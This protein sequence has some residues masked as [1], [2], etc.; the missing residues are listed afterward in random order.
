MKQA[1][2]IIFT[3]LQNRIINLE[4]E[5]GTVINEKAL[6][7]EFDVSRTPVREA[8]I[9]LSQIGLIETRPRVG[10]FVTQIE[11]KSV[12]NAYEVKKNLE[13]LAAELAAKR[14][15]DEEIEELFEIIERFKG[16]DIVKD[17]KLC[18]QDDQRFHYLIR[19]AARNEILIEV[20]DMLNTKTARFLQSIRYVISD[21][22][23]FSNSLV[24]IADAIRARDSEEAR[25]H[26]EIHTK[27]F[28]DQMSRHFFG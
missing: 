4:L 9:K 12:K 23:W 18:I 22:D 1:N 13:G 17:Y 6:M 21:Y 15:T 2:E 10:T 24:D 20:L 8:L 11:I 7:E 26:T 16:Y 19:Q 3:E 14:A 5:P 27:E 28:L 25:K